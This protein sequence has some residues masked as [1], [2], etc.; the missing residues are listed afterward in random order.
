MAQ[1]KQLLYESYDSDLHL[2]QSAAAETSLGH[3][4]HVFLAGASVRFAFCLGS[5]CFC[6]DSA[7]CMWLCF[8]FCH[9]LF[10]CV[11]PTPRPFETSPPILPW[12]VAS[13]LLPCRPLHFSTLCTPNLPMSTCLI[14]TP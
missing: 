4:H 11:P 13:V 9:C 1:G 3:T 7:V 10:S 2:S 14:C 6:A 8:L 12:S 5:I